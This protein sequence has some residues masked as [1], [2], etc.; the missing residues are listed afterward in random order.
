MASKDI[1]TL[2]KQLP[3]FE[4]GL[5]D[6]SEI[7]LANL[8]MIGEVPAPTFNEEDRIQFL[9]DRFTE[10][11]ITDCSTDEAGNGIGVINGSVGN[12]SILINAHADTV[13]STKVDH[14]MLVSKDSIKGPGVA[15]NS[16]GLAI[17][18]SFP[19]ILNS[20]DIELTDNLILLGGVKSLG[21]GDLEGIR[22]FLDNNS[23]NISTA[24]CLEGIELGRLSYSSIGMLR[25][26]IRCIVPETYDW[27]RFGEAS[28]IQT[29]NEVINKINDI[30]MPK[31]PRTSIVMG[32]I[33]GGSSF[34]TTALEATLQFEVRSES[35]EVVDGVG[36]RI[37]EIGIEVA[38]KMGDEVQVDIFARRKPGGIPF[39]HPLNKCSRNIME[40]LDLEPRLAPS[41][42]ELSAL[43][44]KEIPALTLGVTTGDQLHKPNE[45]IK[46]AP[47]YKGITQIL[48]IL[49]AIDGGYCD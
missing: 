35:A 22:F 18:A 42:S 11:G 26:E 39:A 4:K 27:T 48:G 28:A 6:L 24:L 13:F 33:S 17:L 19:Y 38:S 25:G 49:L 1:K 15:D 21:R 9:M 41:I 23:F 2:Y 14:T 16:L 31:R 46:I 7:L 47:I 3:R 45:T 34:N 12:K 30:R 36:Q 20:L 44:D 37:E 5:K 40:E 8:V 29:L 43:I 32:S 10:A